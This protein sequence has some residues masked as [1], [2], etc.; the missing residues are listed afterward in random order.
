MWF[1]IALKFYWSYCCDIHWILY[2][3][4]D[5]KT[6]EAKF[7]SEKNHLWLKIRI[8]S[9]KKKTYKVSSLKYFRS[10]EE[11]LKGR[12]NWEKTTPWKSKC[13]LQLTLLW[14]C[15]GFVKKPAHWARLNSILSVDLSSS[16]FSRNTII[17]GMKITHEKVSY[18]Y[19]T[20]TP[21]NTFIYQ[22][23][24]L[25]LSDRNANIRFLFFCFPCG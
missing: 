2:L 17:T 23:R 18:H 4:S 16:F 15:W 3:I 10:N 13:I 12:R 24:K 6:A 7:I 22:W 9:T 1:L 5:Y 19:T 20:P 11:K 21:A 8:E 14:T 25:V